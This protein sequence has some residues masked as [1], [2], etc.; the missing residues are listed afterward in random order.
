M[1]EAD[2][3]NPE[4]GYLQRPG[5]GSNKSGQALSHLEFYVGVQS[6]YVSLFLSLGNVRLSKLPYH[7]LWDSLRTY[8]NYESLLK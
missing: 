5:D 8:L 3:G 6:M 7:I 4:K 2:Q 1:L